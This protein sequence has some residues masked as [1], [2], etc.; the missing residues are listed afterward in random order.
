M[1][2][3]QNFDSTKQSNSD[4]VYEGRKGSECP[5]FLGL[6]SWDCG[7]EIKDEE[8]LK[9]GIWQI[10]ANI[11]TDITVIAAYLVLGYVIY[12]GYQ[13]IFSSGDPNKVASGKKTLT[14]AFIGLAIV[15][16]AYLI[17]STIRFALLGAN[18]KLTN[19]VTSE[20]VKPND[21]ITNSISWVIGIAG[22]VA[23]IFVVYGGI[24]YTTSAGDPNKLQKAKQIILYALIGLII[25]ALAEAITAFISSMIRDADNAASY[26]NQIIISKGAT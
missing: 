15:M 20:C 11:A 22:A 8:T 2:N 1:S 26:T 7:V 17:M 13:Y 6:T 14:Q 21:L 4:A 23:L 19:C 10:V 16:S 5:V 18:G 25:V 12:G 9:S 3:S 24:S